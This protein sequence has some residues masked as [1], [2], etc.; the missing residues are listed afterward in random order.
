MRILSLISALLLVAGVFC[1]GGEESA[2]NPG[3]VR[4]GQDEFA[5]PAQTFEKITEEEM[6]AFIEALPELGKALQAANYEPKP[7]EG[8]SVDEDLKAAVEAM[9]D[10]SGVVE[11]LE[12]TNSKWP[13]FRI[14]MY[15]VM[16][17]AV[18]MNMDMQA[19][20][21]EGMGDDAPGVKEAKAEVEQTRPFCSMV[22]E[23]NK[24]MVISQMDALAPLFG[25]P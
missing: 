2:P 17:S 24:G 19:S 9:K 20:M 6:Q 15:K 10:V 5:V 13:E 4:S 23:E 22:P 25:A 8:K 3:A 1:G 12:K 18:A 16:A 7:G 21:V 11:A 14:T